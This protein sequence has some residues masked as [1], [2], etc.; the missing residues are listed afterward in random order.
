MNAMGIGY[1]GQFRTW[2]MGLIADRSMKGRDDGPKSGPDRREIG[3]LRSERAQFLAG[4]RSQGFE[5]PV[6]GLGQVAEF[7]FVAGEAISQPAAFRK[8]AR[9]GEQVVPCFTRMV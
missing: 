2:P 5:Q 1:G 9:H 4:W 3:I 6:A 7:A 8:A